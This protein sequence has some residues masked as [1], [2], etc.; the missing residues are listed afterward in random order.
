MI[1]TKDFS[2]LPNKQNFQNLCKAISVLDAIICQEW[3]FRYYSY[4][5]K[6]GEGEEYFEMNDGCGDLMN[7][8]FLENNC[9]I[10]G[11]AHEYHH[12]EKVEITKNLPEIYHEFIFGEPVTSN[13]TTFCLWTNEN[14]TWEVGNIVDYNDNSEEMLAIFDGNP[15]TYIDWAS[16][17]FEDSYKETGIPLEIVTQIYQGKTLTKEMVLSIVEEVEDWKLLEDDLKEINYPYDFKI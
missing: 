10:S 4:N 17:Y 5:S 11:L 12:D 14:G 6:W 15:Q 7:I 2:L 9:V 13:G 16:E 1:S 3:E 8:L